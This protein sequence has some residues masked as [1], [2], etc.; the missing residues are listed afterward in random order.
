MPSMALCHHRQTSN[1]S[2]A[3]PV[4]RQNIS[5]GW[6]AYAHEGPSAQPAAC[7]RNCTAGWK[8]WTTLSPYR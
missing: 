8:M 2:L 5:E 4:A 3:S 1:R 6:C 7:R